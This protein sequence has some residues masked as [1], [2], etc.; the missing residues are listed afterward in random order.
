MTQI[1]LICSFP[2]LLH[3][4]ES[5]WLLKSL[6]GALGLYTWKYIGYPIRV[7]LVFKHIID[8]RIKY[9]LILYVIHFRVIYSCSL[10]LW[11]ILDNLIT[12]SGVVEPHTKTYLIKLIETLKFVISDFC[13]QI[14]KEGELRRSRC[15]NN[16]NR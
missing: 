7:Y 4:A 12:S 2:L 9:G 3:S 13:P 14:E 10:S 8:S 5:Y 16:K 1:Y 6:S 15:R 11:Q